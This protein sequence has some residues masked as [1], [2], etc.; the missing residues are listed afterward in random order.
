VEADNSTARSLYDSLGF[1][2]FARDM[3]FAAG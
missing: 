3:Q 2:V 1:T